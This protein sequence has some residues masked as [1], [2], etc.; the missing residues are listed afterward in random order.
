VTRYELDD[1]EAWLF[2]CQGQEISLLQNIQTGSGPRTASYSVGIGVSFSGSKVAGASF[3]CSRNSETASC[4]KLHILE[5]TLKFQLLYRVVINP[6]FIAFFY[7]LPGA[8][9]LSH[10]S[11][12]PQYNG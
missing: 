2:C 12:L 5:K 10:P 6:Y 11:S 9:Q 4:I 8:F 3:P 7:F 1:K